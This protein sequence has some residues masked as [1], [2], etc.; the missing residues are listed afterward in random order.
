MVKS[1][2]IN[3]AHKIASL[4]CERYFKQIGYN[5]LPPKF[6]NDA[7]FARDYRLQIIKVNALL[8]IYSG[9]AIIAALES[10]KG[11]KVYS[12]SAT[13]LD[14]LISQEQARLDKEG[15]Q[16]EKAI[17]KMQEEKQVEK[18]VELSKSVDKEK[19]RGE[20]PKTLFEEL[21]E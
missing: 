16:L 8:K 9:P 2:K 3:Y 21:D 1:T 17:Q 15:R 13:W 20:Q 18:L 12:L 4:I 11:K 7:R 14:Q 19:I 5:S 10:F 6:W